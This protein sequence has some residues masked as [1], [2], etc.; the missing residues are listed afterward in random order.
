MSETKKTER[1]KPMI[2]TD[3]DT[4][5][6]YT[7]EFTRASVRKCEAAGLDINLAASK[8]MT[9]IPLLFWGAFQVHHKNIK[10]ETTDKILFDGL[11]GLNDEELSYLAELY[12]EPFKSLIASED[13]GTAANP[14]KMTVKF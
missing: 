6:E 5:H 14:R 12:A 3:P 2:I 9:M 1:M 8:S 7:L 10:Q 4:G 13:E 11:G